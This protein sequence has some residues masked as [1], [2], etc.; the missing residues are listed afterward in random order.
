MNDQGG[1]LLRTKVASQED[2]GV[3]AGVAVMDSPLLS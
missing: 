2:G 3:I 1:L